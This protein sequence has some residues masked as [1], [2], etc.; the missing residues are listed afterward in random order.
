MNDQNG[1]E[2]QDEGEVGD[3]DK[4]DSV[5]GLDEDSTEK[6]PVPRVNFQQE[7]PEVGQEGQRAEK[8]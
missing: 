4:S 2:E 6:A 1:S 5:A 8:A 3:I 7:D